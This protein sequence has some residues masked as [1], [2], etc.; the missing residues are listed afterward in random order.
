M[1]KITKYCNL[2]SIKDYIMC[3]KSYHRLN[4]YQKETLI[5]QL[6]HSINFY[7]LR[8]ED[9]VFILQEYE[10]I[11]AQKVKRKPY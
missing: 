6:F 5:I 2:T 11:I 4:P 9:R 7:Q 3:S 10:N 8:K 1:E